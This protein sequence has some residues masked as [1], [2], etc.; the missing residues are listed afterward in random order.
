MIKGPLTSIVLE[1]KCSE[2]IFSPIVRLSFGSRFPI[3]P[4]IIL[5]KIVSGE[6]LRAFSFQLQA[7][8]H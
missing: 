2:R 5:I 1:R 6:K 4:H 7:W 3:F 8:Q